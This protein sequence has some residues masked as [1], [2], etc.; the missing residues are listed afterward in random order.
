MRGTR[1]RVIICARV[2]KHPSGFITRRRDALRGR[3]VQ[4]S[5]VTARKTL[6]GTPRHAT[7]RKKQE[8]KKKK[9]RSGTPRGVR[10]GAG[11]DGRHL[12]HGIFRR[13]VTHRFG[14]LI[15]LARGL[16]H[17]LA[18]LI[19]GGSVVH[20]DTGRVV[21]AVFES[22]QAIQQLLDDNLLLDGHPVVD[23]REDA[24]HVYSVVFPFLFRLLS[25][26]CG[27]ALA[28]R[29]ECLAWM[30]CTHTQTQTQRARAGVHTAWRICVFV[31]ESLH[32]FRSHPYGTEGT[33][34]STRDTARQMK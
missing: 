17:N 11:V 22:S 25:R 33:K 7:R 31:T 27:S 5:R 15:D 29:E 3:R 34:S 14:E 32:F 23:V 28:S 6:V 19:H 30:I 13:R 4:S 10:K 9:T 21:A 1:T 18:E 26:V 16:H 2:H 24:T 8:R 12:P 20:R